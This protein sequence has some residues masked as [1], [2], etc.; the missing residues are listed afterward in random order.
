VDWNGDGLDDIIVGDRE[1]YVNLFTRKGAGIH[2]LVSEG[3]LGATDADIDV[4]ANSAPVVVDWNEDGLLDLLVGNELTTDGIRLYLNSGTPMNPVLTTWTYIQNSGS[5]LMRYRC[6][7]QVYDLNLDGKKDLIMGDNDA[8]I[9]YYENIGTNASPVFNGFES[10]QSAG[11]PID[12]YYGTRLWVDDWNE[13]GWP[14]L[15]VSDYD[16]FIYQYFA[17]VT[18]VGDQATWSIEPGFAFTIAGN[19][20]TG[21]FAARLT[22]PGAA[23]VSFDVYDASGR[24]VYESAES[25]MNPGD[26]VVAIDA[27]S[28]SAGMYFVRCT[29]GGYMATER[30]AV[31]R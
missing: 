12:L 7:P 23:E 18:G 2:D 31:I 21:A 15:L 27:G 26:H 28:I 13:D 17:Q 10:I 30:V 9:Y 19:P 20:T 24:L 1:G 8:G 5:T 6:C 3:H 4:G 22:L 11:S 14:D 16:G 25:V 29:A